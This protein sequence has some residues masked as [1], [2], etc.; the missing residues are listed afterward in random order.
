MRP[1]DRVPD[2]GFD[3]ATFERGVPLSA[4][5]V[6]MTNQPGAV[7]GQP[8]SIKEA[9][10]AAMIAKPGP[11]IDTPFGALT[12]SN[13][14]AT[15]FGLVGGTAGV[16]FAAKSL[17]DIATAQPGVPVFENYGVPVTNN[18]L[19]DAMT[20]KSLENLVDVHYQNPQNGFGIDG[21]L[22]GIKEISTRLGT[23][24]VLVGNPPL[25]LDVAGLKA[26]VS[27]AEELDALG[28]E[29]RSGVVEGREYEDGS[30]TTVTDGN[31]NPILS[32]FS[33]I[34]PKT[35]ASKTP[36]PAP[37]DMSPNQLS[38]PDDIEG[39]MELDLGFDES[40]DEEDDFDQAQQLEE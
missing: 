12:P 24:E 27:Y 7:P 19:L 20:R 32:G 3:M 34:A 35:E 17:M 40:K 30:R 14:T 13:M 33:V 8:S 6:A 21:H 2:F 23:F 25:D 18:G 4:S 38:V 26:A 28:F 16:G 39:A 37:V 29:I 5:F 31:N 36:E 15:A 22:V 9:V 10:A 11:S 1:G